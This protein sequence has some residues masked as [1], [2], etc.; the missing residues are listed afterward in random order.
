[1]NL[2]GAN[3]TGNPAEPSRISTIDASGGEPKLVTMETPRYW[4][5]WSL[6]SRHI[7]FSK[8]SED[9]NLYRVSADGGKPERLNVQGKA[10]GLSPDGKKLVY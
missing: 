1:M 5:C 3:E 10:P 7:I 6:D 9:Q 8:E 2:E 4:F